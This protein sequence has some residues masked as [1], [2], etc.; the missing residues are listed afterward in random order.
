MIMTRVRTGVS[1]ILG[2]VSR[3]TLVDTLCLALE[4][5]SGRGSSKLTSTPGYRRQLCEIQ[6]LDYSYDSL[7]A[8]IPHC[9]LPEL[10]ATLHEDPGEMDHEMDPLRA[11][12]AT[13]SS[14]T[15]LVDRRLMAETTL[16]GNRA[17]VKQLNERSSS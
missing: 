11:L 16:E 4:L 14:W 6:G 10:F 7:F 2:M 17:Q 8:E 15:S 12:V 5:R 3:D 13:V 1:T 9:I